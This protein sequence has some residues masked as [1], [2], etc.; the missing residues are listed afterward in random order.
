MIKQK[1]IFTLSVILTLSLLLSG[2]SLFGPAVTPTP[3]PI[4]LQATIDAAINQTMQ[5]VSAAQTSTAAALPTS[6]FTVAPT[7]EPPPTATL[8]PTVAVVIPTATNTFVPVV[9]TKTKTPTPA[10][11]ACKLVGTSPVS[12]TKINLNGDFDGAWKVQNIGTLAWEVGYLD[13]K[14][15]S[16]TKMQTGADIFDISTA[17]PVG[18]ELNLIVDMKAPAAAG[19]YTASWSLMMEGITLCTLPVNIEAV[20]P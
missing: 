19:K 7:Q 6:T 13:L 12:G 17:V 14:Y 9:P 18:G 1:Y 8:Q 15:V 4:I 10:A 11:Y 16:G 20:T 5:A 3:D 2:C